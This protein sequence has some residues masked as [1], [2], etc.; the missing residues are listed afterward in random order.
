M[1]RV[2]VTKQFDF[3]MAHVLWNYDGPCRNM[4]G[5]SYR[6]FVTV[7]GVTINDKSN[8]KNGMLIDF[9]DLKKIVNEVIVKKC[10]HAVM[11]SRDVSPEHY[12]NMGQMFDKI[13]VVDYQPTCE[14]MTADFAARII[15]RLPG[16][17]E[18]YSL[19]LHE[20]PTSYT[21]WFASDNQ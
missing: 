16:G 18:L 3:E 21:E 13:Q 4:H 1:A 20:T 9:G 7:T 5:H 6:L 15:E 2:R 19:K 11:I 8:P 17:V 14:N 10:D 12:K